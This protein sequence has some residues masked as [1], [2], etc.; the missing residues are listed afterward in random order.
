MMAI[1]MRRIYADTN[2]FIICGHIRFV[3]LARI[4][5]YDLFID[6]QTGHFRF[7]N[8]STGSPSSDIFKRRIGARVAHH[9][10]PLVHCETMIDGQGNKLDIMVKTRVAVDS[11]KW[12]GNQTDWLVGQ[13]WVF[14]QLQLSLTVSIAGEVRVIAVAHKTENTF[15][16]VNDDASS[17]VELFDRKECAVMASTKG[18]SK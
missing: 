7:R 15:G 13:I 14:L 12:I 8:E 16:R 5:G 9:S 17:S 1:D 18:S 3:T 11:V 10:I 2:V 4:L 6:Q